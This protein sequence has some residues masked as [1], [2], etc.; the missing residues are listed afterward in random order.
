MDDFIVEIRNILERQNLKAKRMFDISKNTCKWG[1]NCQNN[2]GKYWN[3]RVC[4]LKSSRT[5]ERRSLSR[6]RIT[7]WI[8]KQAAIAHLNW[9]F[10]K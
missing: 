1:W 9:D 4:W 3:K 10:K 8:I 5:Y 2:D 6:T 7:D